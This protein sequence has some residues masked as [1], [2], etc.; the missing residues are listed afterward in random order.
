M[1]PPGL[2]WSV[3]GT[4]L[5]PITIPGGWLRLIQTK[6]GLGLRAAVTSKKKK[7]PTWKHFEILA[8]FCNG[9]LAKVNLI[10]TPRFNGERNKLYFLMIGKSKHSAKTMRKERGRWLQS[11]CYEMGPNA[12]NVTQL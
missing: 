9:P 11:S 6:L 3:P 1:E 7:K 10:A 12:W 2:R 4:S 8:D 5:L